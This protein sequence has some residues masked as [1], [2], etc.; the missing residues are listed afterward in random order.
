MGALPGVER[1]ARVAAAAEPYALPP[2]PR[3]VA[4][5]DSARLPFAQ[6]EPA[7]LFVR[8]RAGRAQAP[9]PELW[10]AW[11]RGL[12]KSPRPTAGP[13]PAPA[14]PAS[15]KIAKM[16]AA[17]LTSRRREHRAICPP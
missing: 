8:R 3:V 1:P 17:V 11:R 7:P 5:P 15:A 6:V 12:R 14:S 10:R 4:E 16:K 9:P 13:R 2:S